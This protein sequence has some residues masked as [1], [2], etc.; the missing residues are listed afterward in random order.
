MWIQVPPQCCRTSGKTGF[1]FPKSKKGH[2][3]AWVFLAPTSR[4]RDGKTAENKITVLVAQTDGEPT[5]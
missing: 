3:R 2:L 4:L 1:G 5:T